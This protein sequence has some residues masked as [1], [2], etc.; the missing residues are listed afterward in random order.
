M[1]L[2]EWPS[3]RYHAVVKR[4]DWLQSAFA[5]ASGAVAYYLWTLYRVDVPLDG[6]SVALQG[7]SDAVTDWVHRTRAAMR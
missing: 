6:L 3:L 4:H 2:C 7:V 5:F 1:A